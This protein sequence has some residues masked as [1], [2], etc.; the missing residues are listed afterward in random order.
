MKI[1]SRVQGSDRGAF[2]ITLSVSERRAVSQEVACHISMS[3]TPF[4][5]AMHLQ[6]HCKITKFL[7]AKQ[8]FFNFIFDLL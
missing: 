7:G 6:M 1:G 5:F 3:N 8:A 2:V 4:L